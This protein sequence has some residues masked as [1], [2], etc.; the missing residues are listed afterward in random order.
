MKKILY[1]LLLVPFL[2]FA[3]E[4]NPNHFELTQNTGANMTIM[5]T[6]LADYAGGTIGAFYDLNENGQIDEGY[7]YNSA[8]FS[9]CVGFEPIT[10]N[11]QAGL[12]LW[13]DDVSV[14]EKVGLGVGETPQFALLYQGEVV[15]FDLGDQFTGY[16]T[17]GFSVA[18]TITFSTDEQNSAPEILLTPPVIEFV[19]GETVDLSSAL[20]L[21]E[22]G[23]FVD[24]DNTFDE[25]SFSLTGDENAISIDWDGSATSNP[26]ITAV[27]GFYGSTEIQFC[28]SDFEETTCAT[29][30]VLVYET[31]PPNQMQ[32]T[33]DLFV[34]PENTGHNMTFGVNSS[35]MDAYAGAIL[36]I[37]YDFD[38][39]GELECIGMYEIV[40]GFFGFPIWGD[41]SSTD[42]VEGLLLGQVPTFAILSDGEV[43]VISPFPNFE[44]YTDNGIHYLENFYKP[45][46]Y[47]LT[48]GWNMV[49]YVGSAHN[50]GIVNQINNSLTS[51]AVIEETFQVIKNVSGQFWSPQ[52]AQINEFTQGE[53]Y[54][55]Y[56]S[57]EPSGL[58]FQSPSAYQ[59]GIEYPLSA[60]W[61]MV[62]YTGD[63]FA[64][65]AIVS[66]VNGALGDGLQIEETFQVIK[67][68]SGQFWSA[69]F[70]QI[71]SFVPGEA[72]MM[73]NT[74]APTT[75]NFQR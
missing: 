67:N 21:W 64:D 12:A 41:D 53:G 22:I 9:E 30:T 49:G 2:G 47:T 66:S 50:N 15:L 57:G 44:T 72:Y 63:A 62:A 46:E 45:I 28:V 40:E 38:T 51:G 31:A 4:I 25:L 39:D 24:A 58:N 29:N 27:P 26:I 56:V 54:M 1:L 60:G 73:Y 17:N 70:A 65:N 13:G 14:N 59:H 74:G 11:G 43:E 6:S 33:A 23:V 52:F 5:F 36:G 55:M 68:V 20:E 37:F 75:I 32:V 3:Q 71:N 19:N 16:A 42:E 61:N 10:S 35:Q 18:N 48:A 69:Q 34:E 7:I 8:V